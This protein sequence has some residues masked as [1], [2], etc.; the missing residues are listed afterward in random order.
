MALDASLALT[1]PTT[2]MSRPPNPLRALE[3]CAWLKPGAGTSTG[4]NT[5]P[6]SKCYQVPVPS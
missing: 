2:Q 5:L 4:A 3:N 6:F 1:S